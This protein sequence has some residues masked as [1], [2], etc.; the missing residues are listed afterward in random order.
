M[1]SIKKSIPLLLISLAIA[2]VVFLKNAWVTEDA[3]ILF[4]SVEQLFAGNGLVWNPHER[5]QA[6]TS[7]LWYAVLTA[8]RA[9]S[10]DAYLN[11]I[12][13]SFILWLVTLFLL[14]RVFKND[15]ILL[16][17]VLLL[18]ASTAFF[19]YTSSGLENVLAYTIISAY[20]L[21]YI[22]LFEHHQKPNKDR[23]ADLENHLKVILFLFGLIIC[24]RHDLAL[25][26]LPSTLYAI[27]SHFREFSIKQWLI[28]ITTSCSPFILYSLFSLIYY[29]F[30]FPNTAYAKL[31]TDL[32]KAAL[33]QQGIKYFYSTLEH[34]TLTLLL[35]FLALVLVFLNYAD[36]Y[37]KYLGYGIIL[38]LLYVGYVGGDFMQG[39][40]LSYAYMMS[41]ILLL[42]MFDRVRSVKLN[43]ILTVLVSFYIV[44][45]PHTPFKSPLTY[46]NKMVE[47]GIAD[48]RG[49][50]FNYLSLYRYI[51]H[52]QED[53]VFPG[54]FWA[55]E[56]YQFK[57]TPRKIE[58][59]ENI[60][61]FGY[62]SGTDKIII[63]KL[64][65]SDPLLARLP[66]P[67]WW[68]IGHFRREVPEGYIESVV[69]GYGAIANSNLNE[70]YE[71]LKIITQ[72]EDLFALE[73]LKT[74][75]LFNVGAY[76]HLL[77]D[78]KIELA[79]TKSDRCAD[80]TQTRT[81]RTK[82]SAVP[83]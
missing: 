62:Y 81:C 54:H 28:F 27:F 60:G 38:N 42:L 71:K 76:D 52:N 40:F 30:P 39:R 6:Y 32:D 31:N 9:I 44:A 3:Y 7:P 82:P 16:I 36:K 18:T 24:I 21:S 61:I 64:A 73:R 58:I 66:V 35:I 14:R 5:V 78:H 49:F 37:F 45:Y 43:L 11:A 48:E 79:S 19:D 57:K 23:K 25:L 47:M 2:I 56:G 63:D 70:Y 53:G 50:Y 77:H 1:A 51:R 33:L 67:G 4:R 80:E 59:R 34:D 20:L 8:A 68:R 65:L 13:V 75:V 10:A 22:T 15:L 41:T 69:D 26:L 74:I 12:I 46:E 17:S 72:N 83:Q 29:G 55:R